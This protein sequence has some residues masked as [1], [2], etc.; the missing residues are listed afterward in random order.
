MCGFSPRFTEIYWHITLRTFKVHSPMIWCV[1]TRTHAATPAHVYNKSVMTAFK[2]YSQQFSSARHGG[3]SG[4]RHAAH[5]T[6]EPGRRRCVPSHQCLPVFPTPQGLVWFCSL[7][8]CCSN[9]PA[10]LSKIDYVLNMYCCL[11]NFFFWPS[12]LLNYQVCILVYI[13]LC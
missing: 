13:C 5:Q 12:C 2:P 3:V 1:H 8:K 6:P 7:E 4:G 10:C 9:S 11:S